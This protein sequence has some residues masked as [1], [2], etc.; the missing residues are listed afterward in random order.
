MMQE[1]ASCEARRRT[2]SGVSSGGS[3]VE[4]MQME[5]DTLEMA[6]QQHFH[7][8]VK[9]SNIYNIQP[10]DFDLL[11]IVN[12]KIKSVHVTL[13]KQ[14]KEME[15]N[16]LTVGQVQVDDKDKMPIKPSGAELR[17]RSRR[18]RLRYKRNK[19]KLARRNAQ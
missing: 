4:K 7:V 15:S 12:A 16:I 1:Q 6:M 19:E 10:R 13:Q 18:R 2:C 8:A 11:A 17:S 14:V 3:P 5:L 9:L